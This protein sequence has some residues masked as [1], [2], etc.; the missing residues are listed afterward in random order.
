LGRR[1]V[2]SKDPLRA[3]VVLGGYGIVEFEAAE[4]FTEYQMFHVQNYSHAFDITFTPVGNM[5]EI[6]PDVYG[7]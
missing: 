1:Q 4:A 3:C 7:K 5:A 2:G 6:M